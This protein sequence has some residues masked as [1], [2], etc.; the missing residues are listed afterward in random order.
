MCVRVGTLAIWI[1]PRGTLT[2]NL[3]HCEKDKEEQERH[4]V[5]RRISSYHT[6]TD[7]EPYH[8][9]TH[10]QVPTDVIHIIKMTHYV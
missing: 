1:N 10:P 3:G 4:P 2:R 5:R 9:I 6:P 8:P 7:T